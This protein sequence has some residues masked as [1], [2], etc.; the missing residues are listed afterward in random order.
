MSDSDVFFENQTAI[1]LIH[2]L[3]IEEEKLFDSEGRRVATFYEVS[4]PQQLQL[5]QPVD[6]QPD[7]Y[8]N[9]NI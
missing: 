7:N 4:S 2:P 1:A 6:K 3:F 8:L 9:K 5:L